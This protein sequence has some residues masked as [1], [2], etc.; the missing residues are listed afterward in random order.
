MTQY[1]CDHDITPATCEAPRSCKKCGASEGQALGHTWAG[2]CGRAQSCTRCGEQSDKIVS[3][4]WKNPTCEKPSTCSNCGE[5]SGAALGHSYS[6]S[7]IK[8]PTCTENGIRRYTC[9]NCHGSYDEAIP[10][11]GHSMNQNV[12]SLCGANL[13]TGSINTNLRASEIIVDWSG[14]SKYYDVLDL[15]QYYDVSYLK[16]QGYTKIE[17]T[18]SM[19]IKLKLSLFGVADITDSQHVFLYPTTNCPSGTLTEIL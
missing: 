8:T 12:C 1:W 18:V 11:T 2:T 5:T 13:Y 14:R 17:V 19:D 4:K 15:N 16:Q 7:D 10:A 9:G 3:H 6:S